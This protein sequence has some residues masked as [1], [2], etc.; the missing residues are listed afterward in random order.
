MTSQAVALTVLLLL[1]R[2]VGHAENWGDALARMPLDPSVQLLQRTNCVPVCLA[3]FRSNA[4]VRALVFMP[5][6]TDELYSYKR[7]RAHLGS[8]NSTLLDAVIALTNQTPIRVTF[9]PPTL[10][11]HSEEDLLTPEIR[12]EHAATAAKLRERRIGGHLVVNDRDWDGVSAELRR[13]LGTG[14]SPMKGSNKSWHFYRHSLATWNV[15][16]W[17]MLEA[18]ALANRT[19]VEVRRGKLV[20]ANDKR[21]RSAV[22]LREFPHD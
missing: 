13:Q 11:L 5:G 17:E 2:L 22:V 12:I 7:V 4:T 9:R 16:G 3:A 19:V 1:A 18:T 20:F 8:T 6:A 21:P 15:S 10:L 14:I